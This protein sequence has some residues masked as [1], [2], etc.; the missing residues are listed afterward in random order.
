MNSNGHAYTYIAFLGTILAATSLMF[1]VMITA[2]VA[3][4]ITVAWLIYH[5]YPKIKELFNA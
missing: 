5:T 1:I 3:A 2:L 4:I